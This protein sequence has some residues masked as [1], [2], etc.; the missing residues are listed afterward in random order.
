[1]GMPYLDYVEGLL[2][3]VNFLQQNSMQQFW[4]KIFVELICNVILD[5][6]ELVTQERLFQDI[7]SGNHDVAQQQ[8]RKKKKL[9]SM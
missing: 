4:S 7:A 9:F 1:M 5:E 3:G 6:H 8:E 2:V